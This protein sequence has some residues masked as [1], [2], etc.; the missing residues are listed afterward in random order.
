[1]QILNCWIFCLAL[2]LFGA[3]GLAQAQGG[4]T[5]MVLDASGSMWAKIGERHRIEI[6]RDVFAQLMDDLPPE[7]DLAVLAYGH[8]RKSDCSDIQQI[9][10]FGTA[11]DTMIKRVRKLSP[12]GKTPLAGAIELAADTLNY[13]KEPAT[14]ILVSDG[15]ETCRRDPC[16]VAQ[17]LKTE[18]FDFTAHVVGFDIDDPQAEAQL[19]CLADSTGGQY[20]SAANEE[21]LSVALTGTFSAETGVAPGTPASLTLMASDLVSGKVAATGLTWSIRLSRTGTEVLR[22]TDSGPLSVELAPGLYDIFVE[23]P[24]DDSKAEALRLRLRPGAKLT[25]TLA[26]PINFSASVTPIDGIETAVNS[27]INVLWSGP[28]YDGDFVA[29]AATGA[30]DD[31]FISRSIVGADEAVSLA[32]PMTPGEYELRYVLGQ[33]PVVLARETITALDVIA[34]MIAPDEAAGR[35]E[36]VIDWRGPGFSGDL[37]TIVPIDAPNDQIGPVAYM[38]DGF[39]ARLPAPSTEG[40]YELR[41]LLAGERIL[42]RRPIEISKSEEVIARLRAPASANVG[43]TFEVNWEGPGGASDLISIVDPRAI[44]GNTLTNASIK[45][46][47][48]VVIAAPL[49]PGQFELRYVEDGRTV[50]VAAPVEIHDVDANIFAP[51]KVQAARPFRARVSGP[52]LDGDIVRILDPNEPDAYSDSLALYDSG[53]PVELIAPR[54]PGAYEI[55]YLLK[56]ERIIARQTLEVFAK[57]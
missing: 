48:P 39:P 47:S 23:R 49:V 37:V 4:R 26:F 20:F 32:I 12:R 19:Q 35:T 36:I 34:L 16:K 42:A 27:N 29:L 44:S 41:Y 31:Q 3:S 30:P 53:E 33:P 7:R 57:S 45:L 15:R 6:T 56:G 54:R 5:V 50:L 8:R 10:D 24:A 21:E 9:A 17:K 38:R 18:G 1:M 25:E 46:G 2:S 28:G 40:P 51:D 22:M 43:D 52:F 55:R 11:R 13:T 14:V